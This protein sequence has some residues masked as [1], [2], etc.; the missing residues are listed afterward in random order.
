MYIYPEDYVIE[1]GELCV[2]NL[3]YLNLNP[4]QLLLGDT[5]FKN[6]IIT[7]DKENQQ[8]GFNGDLLP[9]NSYG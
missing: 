1:A 6:Y 8:V 4:P 5:L 2:V 3:F 7:F 9:I